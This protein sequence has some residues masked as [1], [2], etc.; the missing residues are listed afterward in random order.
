MGKVFKP[1]EKKYLPKKGDTL[2]SIA[3]ENT[4]GLIWQDI[5]GFNWGVTESADVNRNITELLGSEKLD[6]DAGKTVIDPARG[7]SG[8]ALEIFIPELWKGTL[9]ANKNHTMKVKSIAPSSAVMF[10]NLSKW[11]IPK[12]ES[13]DFA[14]QLAGAKSSAD[15][16]LMDVYASNYCDSSDWNDGFGKFGALLDVPIFECALDTNAPENAKYTQDDKPWKGEST[17]TAGVFKSDSERFINAAFSPYTVLLR[18]YKADADKKAT[19]FLQPFW[20]K[21]ESNA[22]DAKPVDTSLLLKWKIKDT[23]KLTQGSLSILDKDNKVVFSQGLDAQQLSAGDHSFDWA[24]QGGVDLVKPDGMPYRMKIEVHTGAGIQEGLA[25]AAMH[26]EVRIYVAPETHLETLDPYDAQTNKNSLALALADIWHKDTAPTKDAD[27]KLWTKYALAQAGFHP[28]SVKDASVTPAF[29][30]ALH[31]FQKSVPKVKA[32]PA[33]NFERLVV[34]DNDDADTRDALDAMAQ[35]YKRPWFGK[36]ADRSD[37]QNGSADLKT[38]LTDAN[39]NLVVWVDD[40]YWYSDGSWVPEDGTTI[41]N[42]VKNHPTALT[43]DR[44]TYTAGDTRVSSYDKRDIARPWIPFQITPVLLSKADNLDSVKDIANISDDERAASQ[45]AIGPLRIDWSFDE[46]DGDTIVV[47]EIDTTMYHKERTRTKAALEWLLDQKKKEHTRKDVKRKSHYFNCLDT[48]GG[49]RPTNAADY[50]KKV[51]GSGNNSLFPWSVKED[52]TR[53]TIVSVIHDDLGAHHKPEDKFAKRRG[54]SGVYFNPSNMA[55]DGYQLRAQLRFEDGAGFTFPNNTCLNDRYPSLPQSHSAKL[56]LWRKASLRGYISWSPNNSFGGSIGDFRK[57]YEASHMH[58]I[59]ENGVADN[60]IDFKPSQLFTD[61]L[62]Y[63]NMVLETV[64]PALAA[65]ANIRLDPTKINLDDNYLWP[66]SGEDSYGIPELSPPIPTVPAPSARDLQIAGWN[67][68]QAQGANY[69]YRLAVRVSS[70][71]GKLL[72]EKHGL[73]RGNVIVEMQASPRVN[74]RK[75]TCG[76]AGSNC[77]S[78]YV[79]VESVS[80]AHAAPGGACPNPL[81]HGVLAADPAPQFVANNLP[82]S[83]LGNPIGV[84]LNYNG[85]Y[86]LWAH[87]IGHTRYMEHA[88]NAGPSTGGPSSIARHNQ[89]HDSAANP[90]PAVA[91]ASTPRSRRWDRACFMSYASHLKAADNADPVKDRTYMCYK[92][93]LKNRGWKIQNILA[94]PPSAVHDV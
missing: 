77:G 71:I 53:E 31:E 2:Q 9:T 29:K 90:D 3:D 45:L 56:R 82:W 64:N 38:A 32:N 93:V 11:F 43:E 22:A 6:D 67:L 42:N 15:K 28:G 27:G 8:K 48:H 14:F 17:A 44:G 61:L 50:F 26:T 60:A 78:C 85:T 10:S 92:C 36:A 5:A 74:Y 59:N 72:E 76:G 30:I 66:W 58:F 86:G 4:D 94:D 41:R 12:L 80:A 70:E 23:D 37:Y 7:P 13:C 46:I 75:Y 21:F 73:M 33:D 79:R 19:L 87:E 63:K 25:L 89:G 40:R 68:A 69:F 62:R 83:S 55:G 47:N 84:A 34:S 24:A 88:A 18:Y 54:S 39:E 57:M 65:P 35:H 81:C 52:S 20:P 1:K 16:I 49:I 91:A 51:F